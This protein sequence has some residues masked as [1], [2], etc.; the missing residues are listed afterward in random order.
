M[1][2][3]QDGLDLFTQSWKPNSPASPG[4]SA[5]PDPKAIV[6]LHHG[7]NDHSGRYPHVAKALTEAG[8]SLYAFD[9]RGHGKSGGPRGHT[10][11]YDSLL[12][13]YG[14]VVAEAKKDQPGKKVFL[15]GH[16]MGGNIALNYALRRPEGLA[17]AVI[18]SPQLRLSFE[19][20]AWQ[21]AL[22]RVMA[23][24]YP[25]FSQ[26]ANLD[27]GTISHNPAVV[28]AYRHD[29]LIHG[30]ISAKLFFSIVEA[31]SYALAHAADLKI[32]ILLAHGG[33]DPLTDPKATQEFYER[34]TF[35]DKTFK[36]YDGQFHELHNE[37][38]PMRLLKDVVEWLN[39][40]L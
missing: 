1:L 26:K 31:A 22:A 21:V 39:Q 9:W 27:A 38:D 23:S 2:K 10:P 25:T 3:T 33:D 8:Y 24:L 28:Q 6:V 36:R 13:D 19:P 14:L 30:T 11:N 29:P 40:H 15:Y 5:A 35:A 4:P 34:I 16:S 20:P 12:D 18:T 7:F 17:G 37:T 32:P